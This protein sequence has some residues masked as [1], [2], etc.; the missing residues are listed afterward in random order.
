M[1]FAWADRD[2]RVQGLET[3]QPI[4]DEAEQVAREVDALLPLLTGADRLSRDAARRVLTRL[5]DR[6][7]VLRA[8]VERWNAR[9]H[10]DNQA[11]ARH[12]AEQIA[13]LPAALRRTT[14]VVAL[15]DEH[16]QLIAQ[17][18]SDPAARAAALAA[19]MTPTQRAALA[20]ADER[21]PLGPDATRAEVRE[22]LQERPQFTRARTDTSGWFAWIDRHGHAHRLA[23]PLPI[24]RELVAVAGELQSSAGLLT[25]PAV[26]PDALFRMLGGAAARLERVAVLQGHLT[27]FQAEADTREL[28]AW[29][30][31]AADWRAKRRNT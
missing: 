27:R 6:L 3:V 26:A 30:T 1:S 28:E 20:A 24:E 23:D 15:H 5:Q 4:S 17:T 2:G 10:A 18:F 22:V 13:S 11:L 9:V 19:P 16:D 21:V 29:N 8:D 12:Y 25:D 31:F 7:A 14:L